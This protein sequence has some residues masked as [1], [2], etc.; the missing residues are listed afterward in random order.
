MEEKFREALTPRDFH[1]FKIGD[2]FEK[3][4]LDK[5]LLFDA[6]AHHKCVWKGYDFLVDGISMTTDAVCLGGC[7]NGVP[8]IWEVKTT[9]FS[10]RKE[11]TDPV[12]RPYFWQVMSYIKGLQTEMPDVLPI[13]RFVF[14]FLNGDYRD[15]DIEIVAT[16]CIFTQNE[17]NNN[18]SQILQTRDELLAEKK[19]GGSAEL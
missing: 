3:G 6:K 4:V 12:W 17:I 1:R 5:G 16:D 13:G 15:R 10:S 14:G 7:N 2:G 19:G 9:K 8:I 18:W 11:I